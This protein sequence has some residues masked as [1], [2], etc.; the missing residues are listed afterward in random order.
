MVLPTETEVKYDDKKREATV[1]VDVLLTHD[2]VSDNNSEETRKN[3]QQL[4]QDTHFFVKTTKIN[5]V[6]NI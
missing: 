5:F 1:T 2:K 3:R 4:H 6:H